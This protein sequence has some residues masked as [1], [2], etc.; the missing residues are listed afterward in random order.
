L[1]ELIDVHKTFERNK[2]R[3]EALRGVSLKVEKGDIFGVIGYSGAGKSTLIR[4]VNGLERPTRGE[5]VVDGKSLNGIGGKVLRELRQSIGMIFQHF[6]LLETKTVFDNVAMPL[7]LTGKNRREIRQRTEELLEYVGL[8]GK[9]NSYPKELSGGQKQR[10]GIARALANNPRILLCDEATSALDPQTTMSIL[11][12]LRR[13]N[14][15]YNITIMLITHEMGVIQKICNK[16]AVMEKGRIIEQGDVIDVFGNPQH[17]TTR[18]FV[19]TVIQTTVPPGIIHAVEDVHRG[20]MY[21]LKFVGKLAGEPVIH[22][23]I[24][25]F[26]VE[27]NTLFATMTEI[28]QTMLG[29]M[30]IQVDGRP[31]DI[32]QAA[33]Y[34]AERGV[35]IE[36]VKAP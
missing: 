3:I 11:E 14:R 23:L 33:R 24:R 7:V 31:E 18:S 16:V 4:M 15:E 26:P 35:F 9:A 1:I 10:V 25:R 22:D 29:Y 20:R 17:P 8:S 28:Q 27:I 19:E 36:E 21:K 34:V 13:I 12:L 6:N 5:V 2:E 30:I 32:E